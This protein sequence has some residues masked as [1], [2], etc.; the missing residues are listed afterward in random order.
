MAWIVVVEESP[1][2]EDCYA[3]GPFADPDEAWTYVD[4]QPSGAFPDGCAVWPLNDPD[5]DGLGEHDP[6][7]EP[8]ATK[9]GG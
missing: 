7:G 6:Y 2:P 3:V 4:E 1:D 8:Y 5:P 9:G